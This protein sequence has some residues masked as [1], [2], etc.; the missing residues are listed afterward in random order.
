[1]HVGSEPSSGLEGVG[2]GVWQVP[3]PQ[4]GT[5]GVECAGETFILQLVP[6]IS[7]RSDQA[8]SDQV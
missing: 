5:G 1:M 6:L 2:V 7:G 4:N 3:P 8:R